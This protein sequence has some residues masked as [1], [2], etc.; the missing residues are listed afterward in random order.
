MKKIT[1]IICICMMMFSL[2][3]CKKDEIAGADISEG[4][5]VNVYKIEEENISSSLSYT[6]EIIGKETTQVSA[7]VSGEA[8]YIIPLPTQPRS[9][10]NVSRVRYIDLY[11]YCSITL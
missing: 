2:C 1:V 9:H 6:G 7:K 3:S 4:I 5:N 10:T 11:L 8:E